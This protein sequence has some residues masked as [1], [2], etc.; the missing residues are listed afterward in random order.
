MKFS[1]NWIK[2]LSKTN[3]T[4]SEVGELFLTHSF[5][6][7]GIKDLSKGFD[8]VV[9]GEVLSVEKHPNADRLNV[10]EVNVGEENGGKLQIVCG[11]PNLKVGQKVPVALVGA[12]IRPIIKTP[13]AKEQIFEIKQS[14]IRDI[15]S[16]GMICAEDELGLGEEHKGILVLSKDALVGESFAKYMGLNDKILDIDI[17]PNRG[18]DCLSYNGIAKE[19]NALEGVK[20]VETIESVVND[21]QN[22]RTS[23]TIFISRLGRE[24]LQRNEVDT[25]GD[26]EVKVKTENCSRYAGIRMKNIVIKPSPRWMQT[27]LKASEINPINN[28]VDITNYIMLETGQPLH[29]FSAK[30][31]P[32]S[33]WDVKK[34]LVRQAEKGEKIKLL[35][36][37]ELELSKDDIV[38]TDGKKPIAL[39]GVMGGLGSGIN[40]ETTEIILEGANFKSTSIRYTARRH[41]LLTDAA[42]RFERDIDPNLVDI[43][44]GRAVELI[45]E[46]A[47]GETMAVTDIYPNPIKPW[48]ISLSLNY[49]HELLGIEIKKEKVINILERLG[50]K[51]TIT[52]GDLICKIPTERRD[53]RTEEDLIEEIGRVYGYDK[54]QPKALRVAVQPPVRNKLRFFEREVKNIM[55]RSGFNEVR[56]YSFYSLEKAKV[57]GLDI[58]SH[59]SLLNP[60]NPNQLLV[61]QTLIIELLNSCKK[62][63]SYYDDIRIFDIG[64]TYFSRKNNLPKEK[65]ILTIAVVNKDLN[66]EQFFILKGAIEALFKEIGIS[67]CFYDDK[68]KDNEKDNN[69]F[70]PSRKAVIRLPDKKKLGVMG[71]INKHVTKSFKIKNNRVAIAEIDLEMLLVSAKKEKHYKPLLKFPAIE[72]DLSIVVGNRIKVSEVEGLLRIKNTDISKKIKL[73]DI[74]INPKTNE[75]SMA[76]HITFFHPERTLKAK[77]V[78]EQMVELV[79]LL[80]K[81]LNIKTKK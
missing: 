38:I 50:I 42:Y 27:R 52:K 3:K 81:K 62:N 19:L 57:L 58:A 12:K 72:R 31:G 16:N 65:L 24:R 14:K 78:D 11:A 8:K 55:T 39:A 22:D 7:E 5:E 18:H 54:I 44:L 76:F 80:E 68:F 10:A 77:E 73:F 4:A 51:A 41:N 53:L 28:I 6:V 37:Q 56:G 69:T 60:M 61:R 71:E 67:N 45:Q 30:G 40:N 47:N 29:A 34:I 46:L 17:L 63:L 9:I 48:S 75:R 43:A 33:N 26:L 32:D 23:K 13:T 20:N 49:V 59:I 35:D 1:Y 2:E 21:E 25:T 74:Y 79:N 36:E 66:G 70:H 15:E 64:K